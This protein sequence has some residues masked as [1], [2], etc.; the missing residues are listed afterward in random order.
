MGYTQTDAIGIYGFLLFVMSAA[1]TV[2]VV[3]SVVGF[4]MWQYR[5]VRI[6]KQLEVSRTS[7][8]RAILSWFIPGVNLFKPYQVLRDLWLDL[9]GAANRAGLIRAWWCTGLLTLALGVERQW[10]LRL[11]DVEA[12]ST[13][14]LRL[15]RLAYTGM[16]LLA[17]ALC[18][19]VV[20]RIQRRLVQM[21]GEVLRA[22]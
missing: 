18:I 14:A 15:T 3:R 17:T 13:G 4:L 5:A 6:A 1:K 22:S 9:G 11:A 21:K 2:A 16:F 7:P 19:G 10:M 8:R 20:W 12:I